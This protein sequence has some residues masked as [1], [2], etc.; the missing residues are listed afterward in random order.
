MHIICIQLTCCC[1]W[2]GV[3]RLLFYATGYT[4][5]FSLSHTHSHTFTQTGESCN[6]CH[7]QIS[8]STR[9]PYAK[10]IYRNRARPG[11]KIIVDRS[12][13]HAHSASQSIPALSPLYA[14]RWPKRKQRITN[15]TKH[16]RNPCGAKGN[17]TDS[18]RERQR[19]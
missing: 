8:I 10:F 18:V 11:Q 9:F 3:W 13:S 7:N 2:Q 14:L 1:C 6:R 5:S 15:Q 17:R 4:L 12:H 19:Y 16:E